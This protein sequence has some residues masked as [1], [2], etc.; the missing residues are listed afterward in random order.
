METLTLTA[1]F[2]FGVSALLPLAWWPRARFMKRVT[3][4][5]IPVRLYKSLLPQGAGA[6]SVWVYGA[7]CVVIDAEWVEK[8]TVSEISHIFR[9]EC[10][11]LVMGHARTNCLLCACGLWFLLPLFRGKH[12]YEADCFAAACRDERVISSS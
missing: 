5:G 2:Y 1:V 3:W 12:E 8:A 10:G 11:H 7:N 6:C 4:G 9:H